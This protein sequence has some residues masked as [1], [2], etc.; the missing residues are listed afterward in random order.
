MACVDLSWN[1]GEEFQVISLSIDPLETP[2]RARQTKQ[3]YL[4]PT[5]DRQRKR[6]ALSYRQ[7]AD[8]SASG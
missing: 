7:G 1:A 4:R 5:D 8:H 3:R 6:L 2:Q